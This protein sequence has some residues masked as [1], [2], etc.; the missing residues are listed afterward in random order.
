MILTI[1]L[2]SDTVKLLLLENFLLNNTR[3]H[4]MQNWNT[5]AKIIFVIFDKKK[6]T[7]KLHRTNLILLLRKTNQ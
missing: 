5:V 7:N 4:Q 2:S 6:I 3:A 1:R